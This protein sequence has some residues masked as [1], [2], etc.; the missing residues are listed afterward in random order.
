MK[1]LRDYQVDAI[2][3]LI[4]HFN[5]NDENRVIVAMPT[6]TG[7]SLVIAEYIRLLL[8]WFPDI[9]IL[10]I[11]HKMELIQQNKAQLLER[12]PNLDI[13]VYSNSLGSKTIRQITFAG[14]DSIYRSVKNF[15]IVDYIFIDECHLVSDDMK[16][17]YS[18]TLSHFYLLNKNM[19]LIGFTATPWRM[20]DGILT[21][22]RWWDKVVYNLCDKNMF[23]NLVNK[24]YLTK[25]VPYKREIEYNVNN[26]KTTANDY[27]LKELQERV[28][29]SSYTVP[30]IKDVLKKIDE[31]GCKRTIIFSSGLEHSKNIQ[32]ELS[33]YNKSSVVI[34]STLDLADRINYIESFK[35]GQVDFLINYN[36]LTT[37]FDCPEIDCIVVMRPTKSSVLWVQALG[38]GTRPAPE[39]EKCIVLDYGGNTHRL[40]TINDPFIPKKKESKKNGMGKQPVK[41]CPEC[42]AILHLAE[43]KCTECGYEF[44]VKNNLTLNSS[45]KDL[46]SISEHEIIVAKVNRFFGEAYK[47]RAGKKMFRIG[48]DINTHIIYEYL[49]VEGFG[50][51]YHKAKQIWGTFTNIPLP[52][53]IEECVEYE[54]QGVL[55]SPYKVRVWLNPPTKYPKILNYIFDVD[56]DE[57]EDVPF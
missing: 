37:G 13:G 52:K 1:Q 34:D 7:K 20:K 44:P 56:K 25:L 51:P 46:I 49:D 22:T 57:Y 3:A 11:T 38:R 6:G 28:N 2:N 10:M 42:G 17:M 43:K 15:G 50:F 47:S 41:D 48:I 33:K 36:I 55:N 39:K 4:N 24:G 16:T 32:E 31:M 9:K 26:L 23:I 18:K 35:Q 53:T 21:E 45:E 54:E 8:E 30:I 12:V 5:N 40:G 29:T 14:I 27:N 19:K